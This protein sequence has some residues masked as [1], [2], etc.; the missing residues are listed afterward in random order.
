MLQMHIP[1]KLLI[2]W[3][4]HCKEA[5]SEATR[6]SKMKIQLDASVRPVDPPLQET[7]SC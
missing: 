1:I 6:P 7:L 5:G 4:R 2:L 3:F